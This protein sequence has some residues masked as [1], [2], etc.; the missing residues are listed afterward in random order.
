MKRTQRA[1]QRNEDEFSTYFLPMLV[2]VGTCLT[3]NPT[4]CRFGLRPSRESPPLRAVEF[5]YLIDVM[6]K[7]SAFLNLI[8]VFIDQDRV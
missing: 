1:E 6:S 2:E 3:T 5:K 7:H 8:Y 4:Y